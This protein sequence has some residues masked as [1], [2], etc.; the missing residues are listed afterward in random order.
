MNLILVFH[1]AVCSNAF[2]LNKA[3]SRSNGFAGNYLF[4]SNSQI[5]TPYIL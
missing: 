3:S 4:L 1:I 5:H 2:V